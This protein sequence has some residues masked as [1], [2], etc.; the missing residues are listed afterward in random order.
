[1]IQKDKWAMMQED[2]EAHAYVSAPASSDSLQARYLASTTDNPV[3]GQRRGSRSSDG[4]G[5][6]S[7]DAGQGEQELMG[8]ATGRTQPRSRRQSAPAYSGS[9]PPK[10]SLGTLEPGQ[11]FDTFGEV[12]DLYAS[13]SAR[14]ES[15]DIYNWT[16]S[17]TPR[18]D[19]AAPALVPPI[20]AQDLDFCSTCRVFESKDAG[21]L[22]MGRPS[23][24]LCL[25]EVRGGEELRILPCLH[26]FHA[27]CVDIWLGEYQGCC[28]ICR[29]SLT[30]MPLFD[31]G[32]TSEDLAEPFS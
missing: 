13:T 11:I 12:V 14:G 9:R 18:S 21:R 26:T 25:E 22:A 1:M 5:R 6:R 4:G 8:E 23:C 10:P 20:S 19:S 15:Q 2:L 24:S 28:P 30:V 17:S 31:T 32:A 7:S 29:Q 3:T 27:A 16:P